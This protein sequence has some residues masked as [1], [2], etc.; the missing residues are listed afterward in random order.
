M[1]VRSHI[2]SGCC[3][4]H[5][6]EKATNFFL[7]SPSFFP[8]IVSLVSLDH[9]E[10]LD[11]LASRGPRDTMAVCLVQT[12]YAAQDTAVSGGRPTEWVFIEHY[13]IENRVIFKF[14]EN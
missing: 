5:G 9:L 6:D 3:A 7:F 11:L 4:I 1:E 12:H 10:T 13:L 14:K 8:L 2:S